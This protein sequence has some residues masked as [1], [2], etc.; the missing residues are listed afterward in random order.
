MS[1]K[2]QTAH[3]LI[4]RF[5]AIGGLDIAE[6]RRP[7][8]GMVETTVDGKRIKMRLATTSGPYGES[9]VIRLLDTSTK[10]Q[11]LQ[12]LGMAEEQAQRLYGYAER[13]HGMILVVGPTGSGKTTTLYSVLSSVN[14][15]SRSLIRRGPVE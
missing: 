3:M 10:P 9:I 2:R 8:D 14:T 5:K 12:E 6:H 1:L 15:D 11:T 7:Q 13:A 4:S